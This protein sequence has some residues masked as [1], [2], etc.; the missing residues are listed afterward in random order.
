MATSQ[1]Y[2]ERTTVDHLEH[3]ELELDVLSA[4]SALMANQTGQKRMLSQVLQHLE[5]R[6]GM[7]RTTVMLVT[8]D[9]SELVVEATCSS[10]AER[11]FVQRYRRG[12]GVIGSVLQTGQRAIIPRIG[13]EPR[14][15]NRIHQ[16]NSGEQRETSFLCVPIV[17]DSEVVGTLS[18]D[19]PHGNRWPLDEHARMLGIVSSLIAFDVKTRRI[20][21]LERQR[22]AAENER[23]RSA[24]QERFRPD[25]MIGNA[26][27]MAGVYEHIHQVAPTD[28]NV[29]IR[30]ESGT[31][32]ELVAAAIHYSGPRAAQ[33]FVKVNCAALN[34]SLLESELFGHEQG[35]I[36]GAVMG[37]AGRLEEAAG[38][39]LFLD[40][41][42][43]FSLITQVKLLR[44]LQER[45][46]ER[47]GSNRT[48]Y[49]DVR[50]IAAT[51]RDLEEAVASGA[52]RQDLFY[53]INVFP[54]HLPPLR[55][56]KEDVLLLA[57][58]FAHR[59]GKKMNKEIRRIST[60]AINMMYAYHWPGNVREL[61]NCVEY[62]VLQSQDG[63]IHGHNLPPTL[64]LPGRGDDESFSSLTARVELLER[65]MIIDALKASRGNVAA[66]ARALS[67]TPR[68]MRYKI[69]KLGI[70]SRRVCERRP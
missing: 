26:K 17:L 28:T 59:Y 6:L 38:G 67:V 53:R 54:I 2:E 19:I 41:I 34:E 20:A 5:Q 50:I 21:E 11:L 33:P 8:P 13:S 10:Q 69:K 49:A 64:Q 29:L 66:A 56:R 27:A 43:D 40:E 15:Q 42:G 45:E 70:D 30:G 55:D 31:G 4:I 3:H 52:L 9:G 65:D 24:L 7:T 36:T 62:A 51:N 68:I 35:A 58:H 16:R 57:D 23:L 37:R 25:A 47:V 32:K 61:E 44:V 12:E 46:F 1:L 60:A 14:F 63:V 48:Q 18:T 39:T 22:L